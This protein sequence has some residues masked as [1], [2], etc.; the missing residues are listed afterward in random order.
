MLHYQT[1]DP[2]TLELLNKLMQI[3]A[4]N[5]LRLVGGTSLALQIG[6]R[7]SID[8]D[9]FGKLEIDEIEL[10]ET[11]HKIGPITLLKKTKNINIYLIDGI[12]VDI[13]NY[14]Y[15]WL[16]EVSV[17][18]NIRLA[19]QRDIAA[20]K[21][22]AITGRG[23]KKDF[24]DLFFLLQTYKLKEIMEFYKLKYYDASEILVLKSLAYFDDAEAEEDPI[25]FKKINW[26]EV[27]GVITNCLKQYL[28]KL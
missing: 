8:L 5:A 6:H 26:T 20:L 28:N 2:K 3:D 24:I 10:S 15:P 16:D 13:V 7:K 9:L 18:D 21:L 4:F 12:K 1:I 23:T 11:L 17:K 27:K 22:A 14:P 25:M 19:S